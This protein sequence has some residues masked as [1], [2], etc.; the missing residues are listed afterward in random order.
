MKW[1]VATPQS[2]PFR[3]PRSPSS[4]RSSSKPSRCT[5]W[6]PWGKNLACQRGHKLRRFRQRRA[7]PR[8]APIRRSCVGPRAPADGGTFWPL[9]GRRSWAPSPWATTPS[10]RLAAAA[11]GK[12]SAISEA[13]GLG[14]QNAQVA[15]FGG[16]EIGNA[17]HHRHAG[18]GGR[19]QD[20]SAWRSCRVG[21]CRCH[22]LLFNQRTTTTIPINAPG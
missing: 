16:V 3:L 11:V 18:Y 15:G 9:R 21:V 8:Y 22:G 12:L 2:A 7:S 5:L 14:A 13:S 1:P 10:W 20:G 19:R 4:T 17:R 6:A